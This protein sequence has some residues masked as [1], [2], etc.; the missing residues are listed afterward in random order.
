MTPTT[1]RRGGALLLAALLAF[2]ISTVGAAPASAANASTTLCSGFSGCAHAN[3]TTHGY[4]NFEDTS[5]WQMYAGNNCTNYVAYVESRQYGVATPSYDLGNGGQWA[6]SALQHGVTVN[7][8]PTVGSVAE[9]NGG[10]SG[11]PGAG[12][13]AVVEAVG[14]AGAWVIVSQQHMI[15]P[16]GYDWVRIWRNAPA[17]QF[18]A[19]PTAFIHFP[20][21][22]SIVATL[23]VHLAS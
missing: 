18:E 11:M 9:W 16:D 3:F 1:L 5:Y 7:A 2:S 8:T 4:E 20:T 12:H 13:V 19:W 15:G 10:T 23:R 22:A 21:A 6:Q 14:A 17:S